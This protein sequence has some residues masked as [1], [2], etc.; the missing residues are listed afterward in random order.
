[1]T[2][3]ANRSQAMPI[4][5]PGNAPESL[6]I[7]YLAHSAALR[8]RLLALTR[9]P[10][11]AMVPASEAFLRLAVELGAGR[12]P[13][14]ARAWLYRV[15][16][17]LVVSR[18]RR[19]NVATRAMP[20]LLDRDLAAS[21]EDEAIAH[22]RDDLL[23][24]AVATLAGT[25]QAGGRPR[26]A[27]LPHGGDRR[28]HRLHRAGHP[29]PPVPSARPPPV[30][31]GTRRLDRM[32]LRLELVDRGA[33][34]R[35]HRR[36]YHRRVVDGARGQ[37]FIG[38]EAELGRLARAYARATDRR[39]EGRGRRRARPGSASPDWSRH[40]R[41]R[42]AGSGARVLSRRVPPARDRGAS[43]RAVRRGVPC[44]L[45]GCRSGGAAGAPR[46]ESRRTGAADA[47]GSRP[48]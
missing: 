5:G 17:N 14:D 42:S 12:A 26:R 35:A 7:L 34:R 30:Q 46:T 4:V 10:A 27:G 3:D 9:D 20:G 22:E 1:M 24:D 36:A 21:P 44:A 28:D 6:E 16:S 39:V 48:T 25:R 40:S 29:N 31:I 43:V 13:L 2:S 11:V 23:R 38:R 33:R 41:M 18:A 15:G 8:G 32:S 37:A 45:P 47:R 19:T